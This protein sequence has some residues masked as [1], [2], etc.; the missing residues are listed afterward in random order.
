MFSMPDSTGGHSTDVDAE[1]HASDAA[2]GPSGVV[3]GED[4]LLSDEEGRLLLAPAASQRVDDIEAGV[5]RPQPAPAATA[6]AGAAI[7][8]A[9]AMLQGYARAAAGAL[10][11]SVGAPPRPVGPVSLAA[12]APGAGAIRVKTP[13]VGHRVGHSHEAHGQPAAAAPL[14]PQPAAAKPQRPTLVG[15][16]RA[17]AKA[18]GKPPARTAGGI[19]LLSTVSLADAVPD[20][21]WCTGEPA[22][23]EGRQVVGQDTVILARATH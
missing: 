17:A 23:L 6:A 18:A 12:T 8:A 16:P 10:R 2:L 14:P 7:S 20:D 21:T 13:V 11:P 3:I 9:E 5:V 19:P 1:Q 22:R 4:E 15:P